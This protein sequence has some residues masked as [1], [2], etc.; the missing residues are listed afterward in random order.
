MITP[1]TRPV[2]VL[3]QVGQNKQLRINYVHFP[4]EL[5]PAEPGELA[6]DVCGIVPLCIA[7]KSPRRLNPL[8][9]TSIEKII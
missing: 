1:V 6:E 3:Q 5:L 8:Y 2:P 4:I 7:L 9:F